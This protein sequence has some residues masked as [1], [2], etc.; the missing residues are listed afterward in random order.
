MPHAPAPKKSTFYHTT[1]QL[2]IF[3]PDSYPQDTAIICEFVC[4]CSE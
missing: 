3:F 4:I 2:N 1:C